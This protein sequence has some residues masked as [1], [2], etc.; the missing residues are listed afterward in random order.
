MHNSP[1]TDHSE[2]LTRIPEASVIRPSSSG[3]R[4]LMR[5]EAKV[6]ALYESLF[7]PA[8][9]PGPAPYFGSAPVDVGPSRL[10]QY[11]KMVQ[12]RKWLFICFT[13]LG[14][15]GGMLFGLSQTPVY[16]SQ[17]TLEIHGVNDKFLDMGSLDPT[18][19]SSGY[20]SE[21]YL[22]TQ[23]DILKSKSL[24][25]EAAARLRAKQATY[26]GESAGPIAGVMKWWKPQ[27]DTVAIPVDEIP[28]KAAKDL[29]VQQR[30]GTRLIDISLRARNPEMAADFVNTLASVFIENNLQLRSGSS[31]RTQAWLSKELQ[32]LQEKLEQSETGLQRYARDNNL[33]I[34]ENK[35]SVSEEQL[36]QL[37][38]ELSRAQG[39]RIVK[40]SR[41]ELARAE[42]SQAGMVESVPGIFEGGPL[43]DYQVKVA[44]LRRELA[45]LNAAFSPTHYKVKR[46]QAQLAEVEATYDKE[47]TAAMKRTAN[48]YEAAVRRETLLTNAYN[49]Q[50]RTVSEQAA[51][52]VH[53]NLSKG[54]VD[55]YR[56][57]YDDLMQ[58]TREA[59]MAATIQA[60]NARIIDAA[61]PR[62]TQSQA[63]VVFTAALGLLV[64]VFLGGTAA[65][66]REQT[67][68]SLRKP[69]DAA[70]HLNLPELGVIPSANE[71]RKTILARSGSS[72]SRALLDADRNTRD[73]SGGMWYA[74]G[75]SAIL[76]ESF[77]ATLASILL[78]SRDA[79]APQ[80]IAVTSPSPGEGKSTVV[81]NL[82]IGL[83]QAHHPVLLI[84]A[85]LQ[86][87]R[88]HDSFGLPNTEGWAFVISQEHPITD[89][90][91]DRVVQKTAIPGLCIL[92]SGTQTTK[93]ASLLDSARLSE[94]LRYA[95]SRFKT[96][97]IDTPP[98]L[99]V[100]DTRVI[101]HR[102]D[103]V[104][105]VCRSG[106]TTREAARAAKQR[107]EEDGTPILGVVLN[108]WNPKHSTHPYY[109]DG[110][111][112]GRT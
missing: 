39:E 112:Y 109:G 43:R 45:D 106:R 37:Q 28:N 110:Y 102:A 81:S 1:P 20:S 92:S 9:T 19:Q 27:K 8:V 5:L 23:T 6:D 64:G 84:D 59:G 100:S 62:K 34:I 13:V 96:I 71:Y 68:R 72:E 30:R 82:A 95:R 2:S 63:K 89:E 46:V 35:G 67:D 73:D 99:R 47:R 17:A 31:E 78:S 21:V 42:V 41:A 29:S 79:K 18:G 111:V 88:V 86:R 55:T 3:D 104:V 50:T 76:A 16:Q 85:D 54:E 75:A 10:V 15:L 69:G 66:V 57:L 80:I 36:R 90:E 108:D 22:Q 32:S 60:S 12:N 91:F 14:I 94:L 25:R 101:G 53:Y 77:R 58:K 61:E 44:E 48:D 56:H 33:I 40:Q 70:E 51:K 97:L 11:L 74:E 26:P 49:K 83:A 93:H 105:L 52:A 98:L 7:G 24:V 65:I 4:S 103:A 87:P 107:L 38:E